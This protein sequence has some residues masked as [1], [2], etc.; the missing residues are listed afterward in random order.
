M[1]T[2]SKL[3]RFLS[4]F[5]AWTLL[6]QQILFAVDPSPIQTPQDNPTFIP[7]D[8]AQ[9]SKDRQQELINKLNDYL[10]WR[11]PCA[12]SAAQDDQPAEFRVTTTAGDIITYI[13]DKIERVQQKD[14][15]V[16][17]R[18]EFSGEG[19][20]SNAVVTYPDGTM[21]VIEGG[22]VK[23]S[24]SSDGTTTNY[25]QDGLIESQVAKDGSVSLYSYEFDGT[26]NPIKTLI[27]SASSIVEYD[28]NSRLKQ[29]TKLDG[30]VI[31]YDEG[32]ISLITK[33]D[34]A[35][36]LFAKT[37]Q[38][39]LIEVRPVTYTA[40]DGLK[41]NFG[42]N[43][44]I[45]SIT[46]PSGIV[47]KY[48]AEGKP[49]STQKEDLLISYDS[50]GRFSELVKGNDHFTY[51]YELDASGN[52]DRTVMINQEGY[53]AEYDKF[54]SLISVEKDGL[55]A[56]GALLEEYKTTLR[57]IQSELDGAIKT[58][59]ACEGALAAAEDS[60]IK[61]A[62][63]EEEALAA[64]NSA[65]SNLSKAVIARQAAE[66]P[67][68]GEASG[69]IANYIYSQDKLTLNQYKIFLN[70]DFNSY[71]S[72]RW[73]KP[74][75]SLIQFTS[76]EALLK[77]SGKDYS[78][79]FCAKQVFKRSDLPKAGFDFK[80]SSASGLFTASFENVST[81]SAFRRLAVIVENGALKV[82]TYDG[83]SYKYVSALSEPFEVNCY[84]TV[85]FETAAASTKVYIWK[86]GSSKPVNPVYTLSDTG[87]DG[88]LKFSVYSGKAWVDNV[89]T[90]SQVPLLKTYDLG[91]R[92]I[93]ED[94][95]DGIAANYIYGSQ[96][97]MTKT[98]FDNFDKLTPFWSMPSS[99]YYY[100]SSSKLYLKG[101]S[102]N[103]SANFYQ[104]SY[105][106]RASYPV[107]SVDFSVD[108]LNPSLSIGLEGSSSASYR[109][110]GLAAYS[111]RLNIEYVTGSSS[112]TLPGAAIKTNTVYTLQFETTPTNI[113]VYL[114]QKSAP[115]PSAPTYVV[116][117]PGWNTRLHIW[118]KAGTAAFDSFSLSQKLNVLQG[119]Q[120]ALTLIKTLQDENG[121]KSLL[122]S[123]KIIYDNALA[124]ED[125]AGAAYNKALNNLNVSK[126]RQ[127]ELELK[128]AAS[129]D[130]FDRASALYERFPKSLKSY[131]YTEGALNISLAA[132]KDALLDDAG[133]SKT[134][135]YSTGAVKDIFSLDG[136]VISYTEDG[137]F[138]SLQ[139][140]GG[141]KIDYSYLTGL[142]G[143]QA[144]ALNGVAGVEIK[145]DGLKRVYD[146]YGNIKTVQTED[147][148]KIE[149]NANEISSILTSDGLN[150]LYKAGKLDELIDEDGARFTLLRQGSEGQA[151][152]PEGRIT[153]A[154]D[155]YGNT[156]EYTYYTDEEDL[157]EVTV[158]KDVTQGITKFYKDNL[159]FHTE[160]ATG[161][162]SDNAY[163]GDGRLKEVTL[164]KYDRLI[165]RY[166]YSY[167]ADQT[168]VSD[169]SGNTRTY[170]K[171]DRLYSLLDK[172][173]NLYRY[174][175]PNSITTRVQL[176]QARKGSDTINYDEAGAI[177][178]V[179]DSEGSVYSNIVFD[180]NK[181]LK[182]LRA[183]LSDGKI[184]DIRFFSDVININVQDPS[185]YSD[186]LS[187]LI[188]GSAIIAIA[189]SQGSGIFIAKEEFNAI[190][191]VL[192]ADLSKRYSSL[193]SYQSS[194]TC[195]PKLQRRRI[196]E[197]PWA[198]QTYYN[199]R[200][201]S[202]ITKDY[203]ND[204]LVLNT[205]LIAGDSYKSQGEI[206]LDLNP[207]PSDLSGKEI[208]F[209]VNIPEG[210]LPSDPKPMQVQVFA[211]DNYWRSQYGVPVSIAKDGQ[212]YR[213]SLRPTAKEVE[214][215]AK[216][217]DFD[218][219]KVMM[220]G[221]RVFIT[222]DSSIVYNAPLL[223]KDGFELSL[224]ENISYVDSPLLMKLPK[225]NSYLSALSGAISFTGE[226]NFLSGEDVANACSSDNPIDISSI[227]FNSLYWRTQKYSD[228]KAIVSVSKD[229][230]ENQWKIAADF[231]SRVSGHY[232]GEA[233]LDLRYDIPGFVWEGP[234]NL[235][236]KPLKFKIKVP[237][238]FVTGSG[239]YSNF[240][241]VFVKNENYACQYGQCFYITQAET[242]Y[243]ITLAP[244]RDYLAGGWTSSGF[245][246]TKIV[247]IGI[248]LYKGNSSSYAE[249]SEDRS[250]NPFKGT[251]LLKH[252]L[253]SD[254]FNN[255]SYAKA[256]EDKSSNDVYVDIKSLA[257]YAAEGGIPIPVTAD[258]DNDNQHAANFTNY[259]LS[260]DTI[261]GQEF[262]NNKLR[263]VWKVDNTT[264]AFTY[265][266]KIDYISDNQG[267]IT[268]DY[269]YDDDDYLID[270][271][272][273]LARRDLNKASD[274]A[275]L[276]L[277]EEKFSAISELARQR[278][279][280]VDEIYA[281]AAPELNS[282]I[283][284]RNQLQNQFN[285][286][287]NKDV[288]PWQRSEKSCQLDEICR[289]I[290]QVNQAIAQ[291]YTQLSSTCEA[292]D[293][294]VA[295][296]SIQIDEQ[297]AASLN[298]IKQQEDILLDRIIRQEATTFLLYYF[299][300]I[301]GRDPDTNELDLWLSKLSSDH[302]KLTK[303]EILESILASSEYNARKTEVNS[304]KEDVKN[305]LNTFLNLNTQEEKDAF[306]LN[307]GLTQEE[308]VQLN[309][310]DVDVILKWLDSQSLHFGHSAFLALKSVLSSY[311]KASED[312]SSNGIEADFEDLATKVILIDIL[313][314][315]TDV[316]T[317][318]D[319]TLSM[320]ALSK[321]AKTKGLDLYNT[322]LSFD[323]LRTTI[324]QLRSTN[325]EGLTTKYE[326]RII[327]HVSGNH[328]ITIT[329]IEDDKIYYREENKGLSGT[330]EVISKEEFLK[331]WSSPRQNT[332]GQAQSIVHSPQGYC[333]TTVKPQDQTKILSDTE[334]KE[335]KGA[336]LPLL[337]PIL[338]WL[339]SVLAGI[340]SSIVSAVTAIIATVSACVAAALAAV[341]SIISTI[342]AQI[343]SGIT[344]AFSGITAAFS[345]ITAGFSAG[346]L[347]ASA[348]KTTAAIALNLG[349][350]SGLQALGV[351]STI[352][353]LTSSFLTGGI[354]GIINPASPSSLIPSFMSEGLKYSTIEGLNQ[355]GNRVGLNPTIT[356]ILAIT[357][358]SLTD[359]LWQGNIGQTAISIAP[360]VAS[361][362]AYYGITE[363]GEKLGVDPRISQLAG[364]GIRS[365]LNAGLII[366]GN[367]KAIWDGIT[368]GLSQGVVSVGLNYATEKTGL[369]PLLSNL[370]F[371]VI[372]SAL[373]AGIQSAIGEVD[374]LT[375]ERPD[376]FKSMF[377]TYKD[378]ALT[379]LGYTPT[380]NRED[381]CDQASFD[382]A[383]GNYKWQEASYTAN[384][385]NFTDIVK[386]VGLSDALNTYGA[387][388]FNSN[389][390]NSILD[391]G[392]TIGKYF[393]DKLDK[394]E[395]TIKTTHDGKELAE[396]SI[397]D[398]EGNETSKALFEEKSDNGSTFW[399]LAGKED[400]VN[401]DILLGYGKLAVDQNGRLGY[402]D[403]ELY[404]KFS[405][406]EEFQR[407]ED[408]YQAYVEIKDSQGKSLLVVTPSEGS[409][410][411]VYNSYGEYVDAVINGLNVFKVSLSDGNI[412]DYSTPFYLNLSE[413]DTTLFSRFGVS[414]DDLRAVKFGL[415]IND[416]GS[417]EQS[418]DITAAK[419]SDG[420]NVILGENL[421]KDPNAILSGNYWTSTSLKE[422]FEVVKNFYKGYGVVT[423][424]ELVI[425]VQNEYNATINNAQKGDRMFFS[426]EEPQE[427]GIKVFE[428]SKGNGG[429]IMT[430]EGVVTEINGK[431]Y[432][433]EI[434]PEGAA[435][436]FGGNALKLVP[437]EKA[438]SR[439]VTVDS[440]G[441]VIK[442][443]GC[444]KCVRPN[445]TEASQK[446][447][448]Y[449]QNRYF[450]YQ[451]G[452]IENAAATG[453]SLPSK[454]AV[455]VNLKALVGN[456][457]NNDPNSMICSE[458]YNR[459][460]YLVN[461]KTLPSGITRDYSLDWGQRISPQDDY[462]A[463]N[464]YGKPLSAIVDGQ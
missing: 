460:Y 459:A 51:S 12:S 143:R 461:D 345:G 214:T 205:N 353:K 284:Q 401:G 66:T 291:V 411:N 197:L 307:L 155:Q 140:A 435:E 338:A 412:D 114:W 310:N 272:M 97:D 298:E 427:L 96:N 318:G 211:K 292:L 254:L 198:P 161:L 4:L 223:V 283:S 189:T 358:G 230:V 218:P 426:G 220:I 59:T 382:R 55:T 229:T 368:Q 110:L 221:L 440:Q 58:K 68:I 47:T 266:G 371:S 463:R 49:L 287:N 245:D 86:K 326:R 71:N 456:Y 319:L 359:G 423:D 414:E 421:G 152:S 372:S 355:I 183:V 219:S 293:A 62:K 448:D 341:T 408:G 109:R 363:L 178:S 210:L 386:E 428:R 346:S 288:W 91:G 206:M 285:D 213:L 294:Q 25:G 406:Y 262:V 30:S 100:L 74:Q 349:I 354:L 265:S 146:L 179:L 256:S 112:I 222:S 162:S 356:N 107:Y 73:D 340:I 268:T 176:V 243:E 267:R 8:K 165:S 126:S 442:V 171:D 124:S 255:S 113:K 324:D 177:E 301:L 108:N 87:W 180:E 6:F 396:V 407:L 328:Y 228:S 333:I 332:G 185:Q 43:A 116:N 436:V 383:W 157:K 225:L 169:M 429:V 231:N 433:Y 227:N 83:K 128:R 400:I 56:T 297:A 391:S 14:L 331:I 31:D 376:V 119:D 33:Q 399:D 457:N 237:Q 361:E 200:A 175:Y 101:N 77:G 129:Q 44:G 422:K 193:E 67:L 404:S 402:T 182:S 320:F 380:P 7:L 75:D 253:Q 344:A 251:I 137:L 226:K 357:A 239:A 10:N 384:V 194:R 167:T 282:L 378:N 350:T 334:A 202:S 130:L 122:S 335:V 296:L 3:F 410:Y 184:E 57:N 174:S 216:N 447:V 379:L 464:E 314:G 209:L 85:S 452:E 36:Y 201:I 450:K 151:L 244:Q 462:N 415:Q 203:A 281:C 34:G 418:L 445:D 419:D 153:K 260:E 236:G 232:N 394:K 398:S 188:K 425:S 208:S 443:K 458:L 63:S 432:V 13:G 186:E 393:K 196:T 217:Y 247:Q 82:Q 439:Y 413:E 121:A 269:K 95:G 60:L 306:L 1:N 99:S 170:L 316:F 132:I 259:I 115:K 139:R 286:L 431:K 172:D 365:S 138:S 111:G 270:I 166:E 48:S 41:V 249:A 274:E 131:D 144:G 106:E 277:A 23:G 455:S 264:T 311:A 168:T 37:E 24:L 52:I 375:G 136:S 388:F 290:D 32:L 28:R 89:K 17:D 395:Y 70:E 370:G 405:S 5:L 19:A 20:I 118:N 125:S 261:L 235:E 322:K 127:L 449:I 26:N 65:Q 234:L 273:S 163:F 88:R 339:G 289:A 27:T 242:W 317:T 252:N 438:L 424:K 403:A 434:L 362:F 250:S 98:S 360:N 94:L 80:A 263:S 299:R 158:I 337:G 64:Y 69:F 103:T 369:S 389:A 145:E 22:A 323:D 53:K 276:K 84:Y 159:L 377:S 313:T 9:E 215:G 330:D 397:K 224:P 327:V 248:K 437:L 199:T 329:N 204:T 181:E 342:A 303:Q 102:I 453:Q 16:I 309:R 446:T 164:K 38:G 2:R 21:L 42:D 420:N 300:A 451:N 366:S 392:S 385:L 18:I 117:T 45:A 246:P 233:L 81:G 417:Y 367:P 343:V 207:A 141:E 46:L 160:D 315:A 93:T 154:E 347:I 190:C 430:H 92:L 40:S 133:F 258:L 257:S 240:A 39:G 195:P 304:I 90:V 280:A 173:G 76:G 104:N 123:S 192:P 390:V 271:D 238:G 50:Q 325:D 241:Q 444:F 191:G 416:D 35:K 364:I 120:A 352:S 381:F 15:T 54:G 308:I 61:A 187:F 321:Y 305:N 147:N 148:S 72:S 212:W 336:F 275:N 150:R 278:G 351:N 374:P 156:Y 149:Y 302:Q 409:H 279:V 295:E 78:A 79:C 312:K 441:N 142:P 373:N 11:A 387:S 348:L 105:Q 135:Y 454:E 29:V 134:L